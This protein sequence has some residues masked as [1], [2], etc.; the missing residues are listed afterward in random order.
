LL[1]RYTAKKCYED[2]EKYCDNFDPNNEDVPEY[3]WRSSFGNDSSNPFDKKNKKSSK[4]KKTI[5]SSNL[6]MPTTSRPTALSKTVS[7]SQQKD[8]TWSSSFGR[9]K[10][11]DQEDMIRD[12]TLNAFNPMV[13]PG[14]A[15]GESDL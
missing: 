3:G 15:V 14:K 4:K 5:S 7:S 11:K 1:F 8:F 13:A 2:D 9:N 10:K 6:M 12:M